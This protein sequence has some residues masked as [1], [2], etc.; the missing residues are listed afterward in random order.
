MGVWRTSDLPEADQ[1]EYYH[2]VICRAFVPLLPIAARRTPG[3]AST[4]ETRPLGALNRASVASQSQ[5]THHGPSEVSATTDAYYFVNLQL[6]GRCRAR[7]GRNESIVQPGQ[8]T[9]LDTAQPFYLDFDRSWR[10][11]S[12]RVPRE[13]FESRL[14][15]RRLPLGLAFDSSGAGSV[16]VV[17][18]RA[19]WSMREEV[20]AHSAGELS[21]SFAAA[22]AAALSSSPY[23]IGESAAEANRALIMQ[24]LR[25]RLG[26]S[27]LS[28]Q[29]V[30]RA[31]AISPR[32][33]HAV[34][35]GG[36]ESFAQTLRGLRMRHA[37]QLLLDPRRSVTEVGQSVGYP[38]PDSF[39]RAFRRFSGESPSSFRRSAH[40]SSAGGA[41]IA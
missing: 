27:A 14:P 38:D 35:E 29:S 6:E 39:G 30:S 12:F 2:Q 11:L 9:V 18:T 4:V 28:V 36:E 34:F 40:E 31:F 13:H 32:T 8:F 33:L 1:F 3:F 10:M 41:R 7:Q 16:A 19:L 5:A 20:P 23:D 25:D 24:H 21:R 17:L 26:D 37:A 15:A 22:V